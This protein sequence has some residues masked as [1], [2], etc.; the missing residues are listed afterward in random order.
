MEEIVKKGEGDSY[1]VDGYEYV[2]AE[3]L[4]AEVNNVKLLYRPEFI[5][6]Y[7]KEVKEYGFS[8]T[9][10]LV[11]GFMRF[12]LSSNP[13]GQFY[14]TNDQLAYMLDVSPRTI[15]GAVSKVL[16]CGEFKATYKVKANGGTFRLVESCQ[17][18]SQK[19]ASL[20]SRKLLPNNNKIKENKINRFDGNFL[21][22][23]TSWKDKELEKTEKLLKRDK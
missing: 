12:Y 7:L 2:D 22:V 5:P 13:R 9:E 4:K 19:P 18:N 10:G 16:E 8:S 6:F 14:F 11:Y 21:Q 1:K 15:T 3:E 17:S 20:T 23:D